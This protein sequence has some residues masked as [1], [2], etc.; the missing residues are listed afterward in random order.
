MRL[1]IKHAPLNKARSNKED[2][3]IFLVVYDKTYLVV[4][5]VIRHRD[6][7]LSIG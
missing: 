3:L 7:E 6:V 2:Q 5:C 1:E 4:L